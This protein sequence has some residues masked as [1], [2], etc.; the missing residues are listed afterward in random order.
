M[1]AD[2]ATISKQARKR[3]R[4]EM[5]TPITMEPLVLVMRACRRH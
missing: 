3:Q 5:G 1:A 2:L 4:R